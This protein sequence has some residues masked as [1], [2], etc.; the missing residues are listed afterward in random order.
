MAMLF[1]SKAVFV[2][3]FGSWKY[4]ATREITNHIPFL[5]V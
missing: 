5:L 4:D 2:L 3:A 1:H